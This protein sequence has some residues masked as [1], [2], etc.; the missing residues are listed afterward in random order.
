MT[1]KLALK[2]FIQK[3]GWQPFYDIRVKDVNS[4]VAFFLKANV[5]QQSGLD[6]ND[7]DLTISTRNPSKNGVMPVISSI[8]LNFVN[9]QAMQNYTGNR[10][11]NDSNGFNIRGGRATESQIRVDGLDIGNVDLESIP[12]GYAVP[13]QNTFSVDYHASVKYTIPSDSKLYKVDLEERN[14]PAIYEYYSAPKLRPEAFLVA[15]ISNMDTRNLLSALANVYYENSFVGQ[16]YINPDI[17][18]DSMLLSLGSDKNVIVTRDIM[19]D[20]T[21]NK[22]LSSDIERHFGYKMTIRNTKKEAIKLTLEDVI[23]L[24]K[25]ENI[26]IKMLE[27]PDGAAY[28]KETGKLKWNITI[29]P[30]KSIEKRFQYSVRHPRNK[31]VIIN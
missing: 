21:E 11:L 28:D 22:F 26:E 12:G 3:A 4:E 15:K 25:N 8:F 30:N 14:A 29:E 1:V 31:K 16:T 19:K 2:Y 5:M 10:I 9:E 13:Q 17:T 7:V 23:P 20:F 18:T 27:N 6:W 24:S